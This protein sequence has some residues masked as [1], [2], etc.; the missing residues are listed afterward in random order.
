MSCKDYEEIEK[1][2]K[3]RGTGLFFCVYGDKQTTRQYNQVVNPTGTISACYLFPYNGATLSKSIRQVNRYEATT[4]YYDNDLSVVPN[5]TSSFV[6]YA[7]EIDPFRNS[8]RL[9]ILEWLHD[10]YHQRH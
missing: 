5:G 8:N 3:T 1:I 4:H 10:F 2:A 7:K 6:C 9:I